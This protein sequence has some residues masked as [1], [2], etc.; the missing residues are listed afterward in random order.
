MSIILD[1][2]LRS[3]CITDVLISSNAVDKQGNSCVS[4]QWRGVGWQS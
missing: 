1:L 4:Q 3:F 2:A